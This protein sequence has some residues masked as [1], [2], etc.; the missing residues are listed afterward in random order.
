M[1]RSEVAINHMGKERTLWIDWPSI[2]SDDLADRYLVEQVAKALEIM[3][4][5]D[6]EKEQADV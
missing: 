3:R 5:E 2:I 1:K 4:K 6:Q